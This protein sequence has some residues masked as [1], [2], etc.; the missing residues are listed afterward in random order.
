MT[1]TRTHSPPRAGRTRSANSTAAAALFFNSAIV[2]LAVTIS[3][4]FLG[5]GGY[6]R[7]PGS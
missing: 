1:F 5:D 4:V 2:A 7:A 3:N 6:V